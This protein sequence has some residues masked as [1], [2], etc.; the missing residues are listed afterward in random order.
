MTNVALKML[1]YIF[2]YSVSRHALKG[3]TDADGS[4]GKDRHAISSY[5]FLIDGSAILWFSKWQEI[6][7]LSIHRE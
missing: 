5:T 1:Q 2:L 4:M 6:I 3:Y 7:S